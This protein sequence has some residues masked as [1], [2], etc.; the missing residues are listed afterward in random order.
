MEGDAAGVVVLLNNRTHHQDHPNSLVRDIFTWLQEDWGVFISRTLREGNRCGDWLAR[1]S[2]NLELDLHDW[3]FPPQGLM[4][5]MQ[6]DVMGASLPHSV[7][8][9]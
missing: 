8:V 9:S 2:T 7:V 3:H 5:I 4:Q 1:E 6:D